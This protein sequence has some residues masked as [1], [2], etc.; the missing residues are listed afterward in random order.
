MTECPVCLSPETSVFLQRGAVPVHQNLLFESSASARSM[1]RGQLQM[2]VCSRCSFVFNSAFD[3]SLLSY[4]DLYD[5]SQNHSPAFDDHVNGLIK[6]LVSD[7]GVHDCTV[8]EVGCGKGE[9]LRKLAAD[10]SLGIVAH[11]FDP[12]Y[13]GPLELFDGRLRFHQTFYTAEAAQTAADVIVSRHVI[14]HISRPRDL[15]SNIRSALESSPHAHVFFET[16]CVEWI[17][18]NQVAWDFFYE[19]CSLFTTTS[20]SRLFEECGFEV[21]GV[22]HV[23]N[24]QYQWLEARSCE[25]MPDASDRHT[26]HAESIRRLAEEFG[27]S[28]LERNAQW[29]CQV[30]DLKS[31]GNAALWGAGAKGVTFANLIDPDAVVFD[32]VVDV[33]P[34]KQGRYLAGTGHPIVAPEQLQSRGVKTVFV[35]NPNYSDEIRAQLESLNATIDVVDLMG[36][37]R[38]Q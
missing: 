25:S 28:D 20:L 8:V 15:L 6:R 17:L 34:N 35:L 29:S 1:Q 24:G 37:V 4:G 36:D 2:S 12:A 5:N 31:R 9:F 38:T 30:A 14:E 22:D 32:S 18:K 21:L 26:H 13:L 3:A 16:P 11:G 7:R 19:H 27:Q 33:N 23:F 10:P